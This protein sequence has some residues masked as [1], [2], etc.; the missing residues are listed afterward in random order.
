MHTLTTP[1]TGITHPETSTSTPAPSGHKRRVPK[2]EG[3]SRKSAS[4]DGKVPVTFTV[5]VGFYKKL[6][7]LG[8]YLD[9][10]LGEYAEE[11]LSP[12]VTRDLRK[13]MEEIE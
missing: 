3:G 8:G 5:S 10:T 7:M 12:I 1:G 9:E 6:K 13:A 2:N 4:P 11:K